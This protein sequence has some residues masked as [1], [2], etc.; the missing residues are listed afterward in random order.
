ML[1]VGSET[2]TCVECERNFLLQTDNSTGIPIQKCVRNSNYCPPF[3]TC[4]TI[5][6]INAQN[7]TRCVDPL[8]VVTK[9]AGLS[10]FPRC[11]RSELL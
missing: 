11:V 9:E 2:P 8:Y 10:D 5:E 3:C 1:T 7:C 4:D 6:S